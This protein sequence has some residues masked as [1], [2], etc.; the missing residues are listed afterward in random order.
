M[1]KN[2]LILT[3]LL[4][5]ISIIYIV[6]YQAVIG[7]IQKMH[8]S[9]LLLVCLMQIMT[10]ILINVQWVFI[11]RQ[12]SIKTSFFKMLHINLAGSFI[13]SVTPSVKMGGEA[14]KVMMIKKL[15]NSSVSKALAT[16][17]VQKSF[18]LIA[19]LSL[20]M[21]AVTAYFLSYNITSYERGVFLGGLFFL[22]I[23]V[24]FLIFILTKKTRISFLPK[25][26][27]SGFQQFQNTIKS[28]PNKR[29][30]I[31][32]QLFMSFIIWFLFPVKAMIIAHYLNMNLSMMQVFVVVYLTYMV[33]M[34]PALPGGVGTYEGSMVILLGQMDI[35]SFQALGFAL[36]LRFVTFWFVFIVSGLYLF[37]YNIMNQKEK[38]SLGYYEN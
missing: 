27:Q 29:I 32:K 23:L 6:D 5:L 35:V 8:I 3:S 17:G 19:F 16:V 9:V 10:I 14:V 37:I 24:G 26:I 30:F 12:L 33:A 18:S 11:C 13:E 34:I 31:I 28:I 2:L 1:K 7:S 22:F 4:I 38:E 21:I 20:N 25:S 15:D 36:I